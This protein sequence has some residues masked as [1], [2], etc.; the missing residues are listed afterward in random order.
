[1]C[2]STC[3]HFSR[4]EQLANISSG[5]L[6]STNFLTLP[7]K[8]QLPDYYQVIKMP[9]AF[10]TIEAKLN[11]REFPN[12]TSLESYFKRMIANAKEYNEKGS[13]IADD[14]E[15]FRKALSN[16][17]VKHNPAYKTPGYVAF[18]TPI[19]DTPELI[20]GA[21][22]DVDA[23]GEPDVDIESQTIANKRQRGR[24][25][26]LTTQVRTSSNTPTL[27][28]PRYTGINFAGLTFQQAQE[29]LVEELMRIKEFEE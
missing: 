12:L 18:P 17:M 26:S 1:M 7:S 20:D 25:K 14:A 22:S 21:G 6:I 13:E 27:S 24:P 23:E 11:R 3:L 19:P 16:F 2:S 8:R 29:K 4:N 10:D 9:I 5:R 15:R 28:E